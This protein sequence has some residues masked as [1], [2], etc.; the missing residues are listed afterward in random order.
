MNF[1]SR[2]APKKNLVY[3]VLFDA[4]GSES[5]RFLGKMLT[6]SLLKTFFT[7]DILVFRNSSAPLYLVERKG[8]DEVYLETPEMYGQARAEFSWCWK[9]KVAE[10]IENP[11]QYDKILFVD[12]DSLALRNIDHLLEGD[13]D[14]RYQPERGTVMNTRKYNAFLTDN[15]MA[16]EASR[17]EGINSGTLAVRGRFSTKSCRRGRTL[18]KA[19]RCATPASGIRQAGTRC[20]YGKRARLPKPHPLKPGAGK[21]NGGRS[22]FR[23]ERCS[24]RGIW[25][26]TT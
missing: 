3:T 16:G 14:I 12:A 15:E 10:L 18:M 8:L 17:S 23:R 5:Y 21:A 4:P 2:R 26:R 19:S 11:E 13:W 6:S 20:C 9:Y 24:F 22:R 25:T 7:G 1:F